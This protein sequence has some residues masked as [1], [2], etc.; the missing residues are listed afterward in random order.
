MIEDRITVIE[1]KNLYMDFKIASDE[2]DS[3]KEKIMKLLQRKN[4]STILHALN[5]INFKINKGE[6]VGIIGS[7]GSGKSTL[8]KIIAG[9]LKPSKGEIIVDKKKV[10]LLTLGT[11]FDVQLSAKENVFLN[12]ALIGYS[13]KFLNENYHK[14]VEFAELEGFMNEKIKNFSSG[15]TARLGFAIAAA[16]DFNDILILDE[17]LSVGDIAFRKKSAQ[18]IHQLI[19]GGATVLLVS[20]SVDTII[21]HCSRTI[22]LEKGDIQIDGTPKKVCNEYKKYMY[23]KQ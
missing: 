4:E 1:A 5:N 10:Q 20:H 9:V 21:N 7:N 8:L 23:S 6:I 16:G 17:V 3:L 15:M 22:W 18:R 13:E 19:H 2:S 12:G 11:G 14:I